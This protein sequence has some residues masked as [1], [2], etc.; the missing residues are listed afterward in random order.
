MI[1]STCGGIWPSTL[2]KARL[3]GGGRPKMV[4]EAVDKLLA[5]LQVEG[6]HLR[7][8]KCRRLEW[9]TGCCRSCDRAPEFQQVPIAMLTSRMNDKHRKLA[10]NLGASAY[11]SKPYNEQVLIKTLQGMIEQKY[12]R[13]TIAFRSSHRG[14]S[15]FLFFFPE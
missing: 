8:R 12:C 4:R 5:G 11:F 9:L 13:A 14:W 10:M 15:P 3:P 2:E 6:D 7:H 1:P